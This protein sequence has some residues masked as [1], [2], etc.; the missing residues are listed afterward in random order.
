[1]RSL[2]TSD[3]SGC[4]SLTS[5]SP[6]SATTSPLSSLHSGRSEID[7]NT[8]N[9]IGGYGTSLV[10]AITQPPIT[11]KVINTPPDLLLWNRNP[12]VL[13]QNTNPSAHAQL[14]QKSQ[15]E[16]LIAET[17]QKLTDLNA[18][19]LNV[20]ELIRQNE[21]LGQGLTCLVETRATSKEYSKFQLHIEDIDKITSLL[22]SL[23]GRLARVESSINELEHDEDD[24]NG[25]KVSIC[26]GCPI[27]MG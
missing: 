5:R 23:S 14:S 21:A 12:S 10:N 1:M 9:N 20:E 15:T 2:E 6:T 3:S 7:T 19:K 13:I 22:V 16:T 24:S 4:S 8:N 11:T 27:W 18:Q 26:T 17:E 25:Q